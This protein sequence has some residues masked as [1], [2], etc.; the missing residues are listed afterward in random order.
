MPDSSLDHIRKI[1]G[2]YPDPSERHPFGHPMF[3][4]GKQLIAASDNEGSRIS[5]KVPPDL[6]RS[7]VATDPRFTI[8]EY[9][10]RYGWVTLQLAHPVDWSEVERLVDLSHEL[11][12]P[13]RRRRRVM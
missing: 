3:Y 4:S 1:C 9:I 11:Q 13:K 6:Q 12:S 5:V 2:A 7:L 8:T 10:G